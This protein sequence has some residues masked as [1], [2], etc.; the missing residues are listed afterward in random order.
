LDEDVTE[1]DNV[2]CSVTIKTSTV[3]QLVPYAN[4]LKTLIMA[5]K[6]KS[7]DLNMKS[8]IIYLCEI[9]S[10]SKSEIGKQYGLTCLTLFTIM[11]RKY[12]TRKTQANKHYSYF[13]FS[14]K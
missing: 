2:H 10:S 12:G 5:T 7:L 4:F 13:I 3:F 9:G 11:K 8:E 1:H 14:M 6:R